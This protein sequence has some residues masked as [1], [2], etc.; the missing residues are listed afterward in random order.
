M[1]REPQ[2][3]VVI[4]PD[5]LGFRVH[6]ELKPGDDLTRT[7]REKND[8]WAYARDLWTTLRAPLRDLTESNVARGEEAPRKK[9]CSL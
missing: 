8:A 2:R 1:T 3:F 9:S 7:Y 4:E 6:V 5:P